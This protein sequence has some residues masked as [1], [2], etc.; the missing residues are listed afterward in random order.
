MAISNRMSKTP[1]Y[2]AWENMRRRCANPSHISYKNYGAR[3]IAVCKRWRDS[4]AAFLKD[5]GPKPDP[6][7][8]LERIDNDKGYEPGNCRWATRAENLA[9][10]RLYHGGVTIDGETIP[11]K[12]AMSRYGVKDRALVRYRVR[13]GMSIERAIKLGPRAEGQAYRYA[14][15]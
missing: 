3:G 8:T 13:T 1:E 12:V 4:F 9:N 15:R 11:L 10:R 2:R 7:L 14:E 5:I 6:S